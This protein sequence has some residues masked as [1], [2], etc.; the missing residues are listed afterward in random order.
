[1][2]EIKN[3]IT[4]ASSEYEYIQEEIKSLRMFLFNQ[5]DN[6]YEKIQRELINQADY[7][8][9]PHK[10]EGEDYKIPTINEWM[11]KLARVSEL[12]YKTV[13]RDYSP[14]NQRVWKFEQV[15]KSLEEKLPTLEDESDKYKDC[16]GY[17]ILKKKISTIEKELKT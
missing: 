11:E 3:D 6:K 13:N 12:W 7:F 1:M 10:Y 17:N 15:I 2:P 9:H 14:L 16:Y 5:E 8:I 4:E